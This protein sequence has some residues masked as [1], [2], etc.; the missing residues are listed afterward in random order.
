V[1]A[2][3]K[4]QEA[5]CLH[6]DWKGVAGVW[7]DRTRTRSRC[8]S[9]WFLR[10]LRAALPQQGPGLFPKRG[11]A[12]CRNCSCL[13]PIW[14]PP[15]AAR[16]RRLRSRCTQR[17]AAACSHPCRLHPPQLLPL[18]VITSP[19]RNVATS[20]PAPRAH[21]GGRIGR[22]EGTQGC[23][24]SELRGVVGY[25][26]AP[27]CRGALGRRLWGVRGALPRREAPPPA[28]GGE[29]TAR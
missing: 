19:R 29:G 14:R 4:G 15:R 16:S 3:G 2:H 10:L 1:L 8:P 27:A 6:A 28:G 17:G 12:V 5:A 13:H 25:G 21:R 24:A 22:K 11:A 23:L 26:A 7:R 18:L 20:P 9:P